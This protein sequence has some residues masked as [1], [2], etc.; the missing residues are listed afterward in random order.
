MRL[1]R[2]RRGNPET[3]YVEAYTTA[4][5]LDSTTAPPDSTRVSP[6]TGR[7]RKHQ[8]CNEHYFAEFQYQIVDGGG[9]CQ[10]QSVI[11]DTLGPPP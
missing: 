7:F 4:P 9:H 11:F 1:L 8:S 3:E 10:C 6:S 2:H 5:P